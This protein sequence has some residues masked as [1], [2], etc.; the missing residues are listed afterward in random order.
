M[1]ALA[2]WRECCLTPAMAAMRA[3]PCWRTKLSLA[4]ALRSHSWR[5]WSS[6]DERRLRSRRN[7]RASSPMVPYDDLEVGAFKYFTIDINPGNYIDPQ[8][9]QL[10]MQ[11]RLPP[12]DEDSWGNGYNI[13]SYGPAP[14]ANT[15]A[16]YKVPL[17]LMHFGISGFT[18]S[19]S[20]TTLTVTAV[21]SGGFVDAGGFIPF[22]S[23]WETSAGGFWMLLMSYL[24][25][26]TCN[27]A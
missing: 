17:S 18:G 3:L 1:L 8:G 19:I 22:I 10:I 26:C 5:S 21:A 11:S 25:S 16:T 12:G 4:V 2:A 24:H 27:Y 13:Y 14:K 7:L 6:V 23:T 20:G 9:M 15:W